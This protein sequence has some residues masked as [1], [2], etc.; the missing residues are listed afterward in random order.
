MFARFIVVASIAFVACCTVACTRH[1]SHN[2]NTADDLAANVLDIAAQALLKDD[3][4]PKWDELD[5]RLDVLFANYTKEG[6]E[7][8]V[9]LMSFY[10]G[11]HEGE[12]L[13]EN[14]L[15]RGPRMIPLVDRYIREEPRSLLK[16]YPSRVKL[17]RDTTLYFLKED[18]EILRVQAGADRVA[19][20]SVGT[21]PLS[22]LRDQSK[23][24]KITLSHEPKF[25][26]GDNLIQPGEHYRGSPTLRADI[27]ENGNVKHVE[28]MSGS[29]IQRLDA[30]VLAEVSKWKYDV[31][32]PQCGTMAANIVVTVHW[33]VPN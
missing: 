5:R 28:L 19:D 23:A 15:S 26:F 1:K 12:E 13:D 9:I 29:G 10:L 24:C 16:E 17:E 6:D 3:G 14:L 2:P 30:G 33:K 7:A 31:R 21:Y 8:T 27:D 25:D 20:T 4:G 22:S 18:L 11:E 32:P